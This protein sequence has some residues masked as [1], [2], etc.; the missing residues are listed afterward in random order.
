MPVTERTRARPAL[1]I[2]TPSLT[3]HVVVFFPA[4]EP[5]HGAGDNDPLDDETTRNLLAEYVEFLAKIAERN[6]S[7]DFPLNK[8][9]EIFQ[10]SLDQHASFGLCLGEFLGLRLRVLI[11]LYTEHFTLTY[12]LDNSHIGESGHPLASKAIEHV[13]QFA[14]F[15]HK[16]LNEYAE[17]TASAAAE[18]VYRITNSEGADN[19]NNFLNDIIFR[20]VWVA[21]GVYL[22]ND[23]FLP[24]LGKDFSDLMKGDMHGL[25]ITAS[26]HSDSHVVEDDKIFTDLQEPALNVGTLEP[27][28][29]ARRPSLERSLNDQREFFA[30]TLGLNTSLHYIGGLQRSMQWDA[31]AVLCYVS[32]KTAIYGSALIL[33]SERGPS[34]LTAPQIQSGKYDYLRTFLIFDGT[35]DYKL[36]RLVRRLHVLAELRSMAFAERRQ[37]ASAHNALRELGH[38]VS[39]LIDDMTGTYGANGNSNEI[40]DTTRLDFIVDNFN[41]IGRSRNFDDKEV[42]NVIR[43]LKDGRSSHEVKFRKCSGGLSYRISRSR[44]YHE[45]YRGRIVDLAASDIKGFQSYDRFVLR[46]YDQQ[47]QSI[48]SI[49]E[50]YGLLGTR[51]DRAISIAH[52]LQQRK[53]AQ[54]A[55]TVAIALAMVPAL[56]V[57]LN[58]LS[59][60]KNEYTER[61]GKCIAAFLPVIMIVVVGLLAWQLNEAVLRGLTRMGVYVEIQWKYGTNDARKGIIS[62]VVSWIRRVTGRQAQE[63]SPDV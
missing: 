63:S 24:K 9:L 16:K 47:I 59:F 5:T 57:I 48:L 41:K 42:D 7:L 54:Y 62:K 53:V 32:D 43:F 55:I 58:A 3:R 20:E 22:R 6:N 13:E 52:P 45:L 40:L 50:R 26:S 56:A 38:E 28:R 29:K 39:D 49:G 34:N 1:N 37:V 46:N 51:V 31:N 2:T 44:Y 61:L 21:L 33:L 19:D 11:V 27:G 25:V 30:A 35:N 4:R 14:K 10:D 12:I 36:G 23:R 60:Y 17:A 15:I 18:D 8:T